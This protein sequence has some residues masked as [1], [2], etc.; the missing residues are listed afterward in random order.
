MWTHL[1]RDFK[2]CESCRGRISYCCLHLYVVFIAYLPSTGRS[3]G[4]SRQSKTLSKRQTP[5]EALN[6]PIIV[7][8]VLSY[9][10]I[11]FLYTL[12]PSNSLKTFSYYFIFLFICT[13]YINAATNSP[14]ARDMLSNPF[15]RKTPIHCRTAPP[16]F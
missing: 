1:P 16:I 9:E 3:A 11:F 12:F 13:D 7:L 2:P 6:Y 15:T 5:S 10:K 14:M 8:H 4:K